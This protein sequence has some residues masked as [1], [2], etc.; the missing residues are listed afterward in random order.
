MSLGA[1][2]CSDAGKRELATSNFLIKSLDL[3]VS[4]ASPSPCGELAADGVRVAADSTFPYD[5][6]APT[7]IDQGG[8]CRLVPF[9]IASQFLV[10]EVGAGFGKAKVGAARVA[11]PEAA[12]HKHDSF[13][14]RQNQIGFA[15]QSLGMQSISEAGSPELLPHPQFR[16]GVLAPDT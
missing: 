4:L 14:F 10:P 9:L 6:N 8:N 13:P 12:M 5:R 16:A 15:W 11:M 2:I 7:D 1:S 3:D